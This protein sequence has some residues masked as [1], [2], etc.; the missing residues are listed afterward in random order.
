MTPVI[1]VLAAGPLQVPAIQEAR[2]LGIRTI[3]IDQ[4]PSAPGLAIAD[5]GYVDNILDP[6]IVVRIAKAESASGI[7]TLCTD[8]PVRTVAS[9]CQAIGAPALSICASECATDK[10]MMRQ[11]LDEYG[12]PCPRFTAV[13]TLEEASR[14]A[15]LFGY[16][17]AVKIRHGAG[18]RGIYRADSEQALS[19]RL[20]EARAIQPDGP[21]LVEEWVEGPEISVEGF[22]CDGATHI[23]AIT[24]KLLYQ[25]SS[26][27][28]LGHTQASSH[29][30]EIQQIVRECVGK[31]IRALGINWSCF[32]AELKLSASG[33]RIIEI[34]A[35]LGGDRISTHITPLSTGF[36][37]LR[38]AILIA[39]GHCPSLTP[40]Q[41]RGA[42]IRYFD[43][44]HT[45]ALK[46]ISGVRRIYDIPGLELLYLASERDGSLRPGF[47]I[48]PIRSSL[49]RYGHVIFSGCNAH[50]AVTRAEK[51]LKA[52]IFEFADGMRRDASGGSVY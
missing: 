38:A 33:P 48:G 7:M 1:V 41:D 23:I 12:A 36:N 28:E 22:C 43:T 27:V 5:V 2:A 46:C 35:R 40:I 9:A 42:A 19:G 8:A 31:G 4:N 37:L 34:G 21:L 51:A 29:S 16:P 50:E 45:G 52:I 14:A 11:K 24:D 13:H 17:V 47:S 32:H 10:W 15:L 44:R 25:G 3:A 49:D 39:L 6:A 26:P 30:Q 18:S 20:A